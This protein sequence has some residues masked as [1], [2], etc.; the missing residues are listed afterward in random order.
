MVVVLM[1]TCAQ[2]SLLHNKLAFSES[3]L[4]VIHSATQLPHIHMQPLPQP[5]SVGSAMIFLKGGDWGKISSTP[6]PPVHRTSMPP[7]SSH[8][9][10]APALLATR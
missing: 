6:M 10:A 3:F 9:T 2:Y 1:L 5:F 4:C 7:Q 8:L